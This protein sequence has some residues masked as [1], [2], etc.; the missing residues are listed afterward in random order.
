MSGS[1][2]VAGGA[3]G[4]GKLMPSRPPEAVKGFVEWARGWLQAR[5]AAR[6]A[7]KTRAE[8]V[9]RALDDAAKEYDDAVAARDGATAATQA[10]AEDKELVGQALAVVA[11]ARTPLGADSFATLASAFHAFDLHDLA[12]DG[13]R[14]LDEPGAPPSN[15]RVAHPGSNQNL[16]AARPLTSSW[17][18]QEQPPHA[19]RGRSA[20]A[21]RSAPAARAAPAAGRTGREPSAVYAAC[22]GAVRGQRRTRCSAGSDDTGAI[23]ALRAAALA[24]EVARATRARLGPRVVVDARGGAGG[25]AGARGGHAARL[26]RPGAR[27]RGRSDHG[28][29]RG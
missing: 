10:L 13:V 28:R 26:G 4:P 24:I 11:G 5:I 8:E 12:R 27:R 15:A 7:L 9:K 25:S 14:V 2:H 6:R 23:S 22:D 21:A 16:L 29:W 20:L 18:G 17:C 19:P 3:R 1:F